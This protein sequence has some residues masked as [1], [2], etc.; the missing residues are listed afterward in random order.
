MRSL[1][2]LMGTSALV[3][4]ALTGCSAVRVDGSQGRD[5]HCR[6]CCVG[7]K[8]DTTPALREAL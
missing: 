2:L 1:I 6:H 4:G 8:W 3:A 7:R 5:D